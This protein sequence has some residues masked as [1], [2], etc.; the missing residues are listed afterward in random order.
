MARDTKSPKT[1]LVACSRLVD[2]AG[3]EM[4]SLEIAESLIDLGYSVTLVA[5]EVGA[6]LAS[7]IELLGIK[8][9]DLSTSSIKG[10][11]FELIW[12]SHYIA[13]YHLLVN[14]G[15]SAKIGVFSSLSYFEPIE[16]PPLPLISFSRYVVNSDEN[17]QHFK[18]QYPELSACVDVFP[19]AAPDGFF[20]AYQRFQEARLTSIAIISNHLPHELSDLIPQLKCKG[21]KVDLIGLQGKRVRVTPDILSTYSAVITIGKSVQYCLAQ[22]VPVFCYDHF[23]GPGWITLNCFEAAFAKNFSGR[24]TYAPR[25]SDALGT[26]VLSGFNAV[27]NQRNALRQLAQTHFDL[28]ANLRGVLGIARQSQFSVSLSSTER[29]VLSRESKLFISQRQIIANN[30]HAFAALSTQIAQLDQS[31]AAREG[32]ITE[33]GRAAASLASQV[34]A[35]KQAATAHEKERADLNLALGLR[36]ESLDRSRAELSSVLASTSWKLTLPLRTLKTG[37]RV[38]GAH[39]HRWWARSKYVLRHEG[40]SGFSRRTLGF[41]ARHA[42]RKIVAWSLERFVMV[43]K[44]PIA[45]RSL[46]LVSFVIPIYDRTDLLRDAI[47]S[48]LRQTISAFE[49]ILVTDGS[50]PAT[51]AVVN[52]FRADPRVKIFNYPLSS[53]NAVRGRNKGI[54]EARGKYIA[55]LDSDDIA[56]PDRLEVCL[57]LLESGTADVVYGAWRALLNGTRETEALVH[58]QVVHSPDCDLAMLETTCVPCQSTVMVRREMLMRAGFLKPRMQYRED[59]ELWVRLAFFSARFKSVPHVLADLRLH[60][61]NNEL[62]FKGNDLQWESL[63]KQEYRLPGPHP[64]KIAFLLAGLGISGGAAVVLKHVSMLMEAGHDA[65]V[66]DVGG[67]GD[68]AWFGNPAIPVYRL[69]DVVNYGLENIDM[70]FATYWTTCEWLDKIPSRRKLYLVQSDERLFYE[71][72]LLKQQV[73]ITYRRTYEYVVIAQWLVDMFRQ[74]FKQQVTY[75][76]NGIDDSLFYPDLPLERKNS[77]RLRVLIEGPISVPFKGMSE[78]YAACS[79]LDCELWIVSSNGRPEVGWKYD[80]FFEGVN[81]SEMRSIYSSCD[82]L[83]KMSRVESFAYP[84]L[85]AMACGCAVVV[86]EVRGGIEYACD[87]ENVLKVPLG[88]VA[89][90]RAAVHRLLDNAHLRNDLLQAGYATVKQWTWAAP[91]EAMLGLV[92]GP[93]RAHSLP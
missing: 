45:G 6:E 36:G 74:E 54:L 40:L 27:V 55:F 92:E 91:K 10:S 61:G 20:S 53:G 68:I 44:D 23:G 86:G 28:A 25:T 4:T 82:V 81:Q 69:K 84:P 93:A 58:G 13:A 72:K 71:D 31:M 11:V 76:P 33:L 32:Q 70:L 50:P 24:C 79:S 7:E 64:K 78:A 42:K 46:P 88:D 65:F 47:E 67:H 89:A 57:P 62:N 12:I 37:S 85:E 21:I 30:H 56:A 87:G 49:V 35:L 77:K 80:R 15:V 16:A 17:L 83:L 3:A 66:I 59:H 39:S 41:I 9:I 8:C 75:V 1:A 43:T 34:A 26:E 18:V 48:T 60:A 38:F 90:A 29:N 14:E 52:E 5:L 22:G 19:N 73:E 63:V 2:F 51:L